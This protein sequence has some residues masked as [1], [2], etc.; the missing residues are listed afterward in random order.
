MVSE[1]DVSRETV[2]ENK[3]KQLFIYFCEIPIAKRSAM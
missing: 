1:T 3:F 2:A